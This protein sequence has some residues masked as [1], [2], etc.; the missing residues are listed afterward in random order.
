MY[1]VYM[2][3]CKDGSLYTGYCADLKLREAAHNQGKG[4]AYTRA[5]LP[6][7]FVYS[8]RFETRSEA[9]K[10]EYAIKK[11]SKQEKEGL[12]FSSY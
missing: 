9:M 7:T 8:E 2:A 10:R 4:A 3:R 6:V 5:R 11:M 12:A 1:F